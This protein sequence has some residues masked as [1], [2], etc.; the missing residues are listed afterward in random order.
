VTK[1]VN[2]GELLVKG[3]YGLTIFGEITE[4]QFGFGMP[5]TRASD[6]LAKQRGLSSVI[7]LV[8]TFDGTTTKHL[9]SHK[10]TIEPHPI[11]VLLDGLEGIVG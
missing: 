3:R 7:N 10:S 1:T 2:V 5:G 4:V 8:C 11:L 6:K 9:P